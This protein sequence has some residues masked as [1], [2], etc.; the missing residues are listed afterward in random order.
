M[1]KSQSIYKKFILSSACVSC[2]ALIS[3]VLG[4]FRDIIILNWAGV[5]AITDAYI[6]AVKFP[7]LFRKVISDGSM[8][9]LLIPML[10][11]LKLKNKNPNAFL[12]KLIVKLCKCII[13][14]MII[15]LLFIKY[16]TYFIFPNLSSEAAL[17]FIKFSYFILPSLFFMGLSSVLVSS[18]NFN[19]K[20][21]VC[22]VSSAICNIIAIATLLIC[23][24]FNLP[25]S[26]I[27]FAILLGNIV[28]FIWIIFHAWRNNLIPLYEKINSDD[29]YEKEFMVFKKKFINISFSSGISQIMIM[30]SSWFVSF[31]PTG[32]ISYLAFADRIMQVPLSL[33][34]IVFST[35]FLL[36]LTQYIKEKEIYK[37]K[38]LYNQVW[39][40]GLVGS[41]VISI[42]IF[43]LSLPICK[44]LFLRGKMTLIDVMHIS[45]YLKIYILSVPA[46][47]LSKIMN[48]VF[49][50]YDNTKI[51]LRGAM[52][53]FASNFVLMPILFH[54][55]SFGIS[56]SFL[57]SA[58]IYALYLFIEIRKERFL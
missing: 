58:W 56:I 50:A 47:T 44:I 46:Y 4:Y 5:G 7:S 20:F 31:L 11:D 19:K 37:A 12:A 26:L 33:I 49:F 22:A 3:R 27:G 16:G 8:N 36:Y 51:P 30:F 53:Q 42:L 21:A 2:F 45:S 10:K 18:L 15:F 48:A 25:F 29:M 54:M 14:V 1:S 32:N 28:Q 23:Y 52:A 38:E 43:F 9:N 17:Y 41:S 34:G 24:K 40:Y 13:I 55:G 6:L 35:T 57:I 39:I